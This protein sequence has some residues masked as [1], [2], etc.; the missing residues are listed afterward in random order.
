VAGWGRR[1]LPGTVIPAADLEAASEYAVLLRGLGRSYGDSAAPPP[2][3]PVVYSTE[4]ADRILSFDRESGRIRAEA[5]LTLRTLN[6]LYL[7]RRWFVPV[8]PGTQFVTLGGMVAA[9]VHGKNHHIDGCF[10][11]HVEALRLR[12]AEG[13]IVDCSRTREAALFRA[14]IGGMGLTGALRAA[15]SEWPFTVGWGDCL[16]RGRSMGRGVLMCGRWADADEAPRHPP[17]SRWTMSVPFAWP[18]GLLARPTVRAFNEAYFHLSPRLAEFQAI[19]R[20]WDP[21]G[22]IRSAQSVRLFG[23]Q[24]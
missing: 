2:T 8:S 17:P 9:D 23:D 16:A 11:D 14:S 1:C 22:R 4:L 7:R 21:Y 5:G 19:R 15:A 13:R 12:V 24:P 20:T 10:G 18:R 3:A 6:E